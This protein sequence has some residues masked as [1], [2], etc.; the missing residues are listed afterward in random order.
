[1][2]LRLFPT[3]EIPPTLVPRG[4]EQDFEVVADNPLNVQAD[5]N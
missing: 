3:E 4:G 2:P 1:M 5:L